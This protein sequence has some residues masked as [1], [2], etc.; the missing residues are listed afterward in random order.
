MANYAT[1]TLTEV[2]KSNLYS[3]F[4]SKTLNLDTVEQK[5]P[6]YKDFVNQTTGQNLLVNALRAGDYSYL[7]NVP[8]SYR[9]Q[10]SFML[11]L[12]F[13]VKN[14][15]NATF[16]I[17]TYFSPELQNDP[18][19]GKMIIK[20]EPYLINNTP[21]ASNREF[22]LQN[23][24]TNPD[25]RF[26]ISNTLRNDPTFLRDYKKRYGFD[27]EVHITPAAVGAAATAVVTNNILNLNQEQIGETNKKEDQATIPETIQNTIVYDIPDKKPIKNLSQVEKE[28]SEGLINEENEKDAIYA[29]KVREG[30]ATEEELKNNIADFIKQIEERRK[31]LLTAKDFLGEDEKGFKN[32]GDLFSKQI[33]A[34]EK[35]GV[36]VTAYRTQIEELK[37]EYL[38]ELKRGKDII[39]EEYRAFAQKTKS[40]KPNSEAFATLAEEFLPKDPKKREAVFSKL[41]KIVVKERKGTL[42]KDEFVMLELT[43]ARIDDYVK[44]T[45]KEKVQLYTTP[46][47]REAI[48]DEIKSKIKYLGRHTKDPYSIEFIL[49]NYRMIRQQINK[50]DSEVT[51][52]S[53]K[54][55]DII[56]QAWHREIKEIDFENILYHRD[57]KQPTIATPVMGETDT[58]D[59]K[60]PQQ[61]GTPADILEMTKNLASGDLTEAMKFV[62]E[63]KE[64]IIR[65]A[66]QNPVK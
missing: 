56:R 23:V 29:A 6:R 19:L 4:T 59:K 66:M 1:T 62:K 31:T 42:D 16:A 28:R 57:P 61:K 11:P 33:D 35:Q 5:D 41:Y 13:A 20:D 54:I 53:A 30:S 24:R 3:E 8:D 55:E 60:L 50:F 12:L 51:F 2:E 7:N 9:G 48:M 36:D 46:I 18:E 58:S 21:L 14:G 63:N 26:Y 47:T 43:R 39:F 27:P 38:K 25:L 17:F 45:N 10:E 37:Q 49:D 65:L 34:L 15:P 22:I 52:D 64:A 32:K 40:I 44:R